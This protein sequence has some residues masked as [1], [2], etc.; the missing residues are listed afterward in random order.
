M[1]EQGKPQFSFHKELKDLTAGERTYLE[2]EHICS[3][4]QT[5]IRNL[6]E[7][8]DFHDAQARAREELQWKKTPLHLKPICTS[9]L[10]E[11]NHKLKTSE[12]KGKKNKV[13]N[14]LLLHLC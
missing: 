11:K 5:A 7:P 14:V 8:K 3:R 9:S 4:K 12:K 10:P 1:Y 6:K 2:I 13:G